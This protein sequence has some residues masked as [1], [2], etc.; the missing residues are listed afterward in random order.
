MG[1]RGSGPSPGKSQV[2]IGFLR[3]SGTDPQKET[4]GP[5]GFNCFSK[6]VRTALCEKCIFLTKENKTPPTPHP[7]SCNEAQVSF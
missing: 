2:A 4:I 6:E 7:L 5:L 3:N 1:A